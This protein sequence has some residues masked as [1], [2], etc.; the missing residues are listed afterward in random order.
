[1]W[2]A[3]RWKHALAGRLAL[4]AHTNAKAQQTAISAPIAV[5]IAE[6][7]ADFKWI[8][9]ACGFRGSP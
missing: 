2:N 3:T 1:M 9:G 8:V 4:R 7:H 5:A 6:I